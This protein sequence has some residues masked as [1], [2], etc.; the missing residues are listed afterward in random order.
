M[1]TCIPSFCCLPHSI[2]DGSKGLATHKGQFPKTLFTRPIPTR[3]ES[4]WSLSLGGNDPG[5]PLRAIGQERHSHLGARGQ[6]PHSQPGTCKFCACDN[7]VFCLELGGR[8]HS[9][10]PG[11]CASCPPHAAPLVQCTIRVLVPCMFYPAPIGQRSIVMSVSVC[12]SVCVCLSV[13][14]RIFGTTRPIFSKFFLHVTDG[15]VSVLLRRC[16]DTLCA[17]V[18]S[19]HKPRLL[20]VAAQLKHS[21]HAVL[22]LATKCA[23]F[24][25]KHC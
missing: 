22:G 10:P 15:C 2:G 18:M 20:D 11:L 19:A 16:S 6:E 3:G 12:L 13:R 9:G 24:V 5:L 23:Q 14:Y 8:L 7:T 17:F 25:V 4:S 21:V 1:Y